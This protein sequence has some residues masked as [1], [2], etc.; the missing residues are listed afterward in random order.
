VKI[1]INRA[2]WISGEPSSNELPNNSSGLGS[3]ALLNYDGYRCC[4][5]FAAKAITKRPWADFDDVIDPSCCDFD[6]E[7]LNKRCKGESEYRD[8]TRFANACITINDNP[9]ISRETREKKLIAR[10]AKEGHE[11]EFYGKYKAKYE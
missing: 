11:L 4:L 10:F 9:H 2:K 1:R 3:T 5:G 7:G 6:I 8:N